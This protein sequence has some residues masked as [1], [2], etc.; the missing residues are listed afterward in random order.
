[1]ATFQSQI[2]ILAAGQHKLHE[3]IQDLTDFSLYV[4][5]DELNT[6]IKDND[7]NDNGKYIMIQDLGNKNYEGILK[8]INDSALCLM[9]YNG[10]YNCLINNSTNE[11][12]FPEAIQARSL[13]INTNN[14]KLLVYKYGETTTPTTPSFVQ[15]DKVESKKTVTDNH[16]GTYTVNLETFVTGS[17]V[18]TATETQT[19]TDIIIVI[20]QS[21]SMSYKIAS[22]FALSF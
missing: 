3:R 18:T 2:N 19:P 11:L 16:D 12:T 9:D 1:M 14:K 4:N 10:N 8:V 7:N 5:Y 17:K 20:D 22:D 15:N 21:G 6:L 13:S